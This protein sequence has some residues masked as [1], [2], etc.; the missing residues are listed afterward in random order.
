MIQ[1]YQDVMVICCWIDRPNLFIT[2]ICNPKLSEIQDYL[3]WISEQKKKKD[4]QP[5]IV[6]CVFKTK[7]DQLMRDLLEGQHFGHVMASKSKIKIFF[8]NKF[9][10]AFFN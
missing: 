6:D 4:D 5:G 8:I 9:S 1:N 10:F 7:V 3:N 2:F